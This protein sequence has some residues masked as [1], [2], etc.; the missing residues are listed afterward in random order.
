MSA[1]YLFFDEEALE[2]V[3]YHASNPPPSAKPDPSGFGLS[4]GADESGLS[5]GADEWGLSIGA[6]EWTLQVMRD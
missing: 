6:D 3:A 4:I 2:F 1:A 5:I